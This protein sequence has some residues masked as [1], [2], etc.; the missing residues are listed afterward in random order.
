MRKYKENLENWDKKDKESK[1]KVFKKKERGLVDRLNSGPVICAEVNLNCR[2][3]TRNRY[4][5]VYPV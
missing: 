2:S 3:L 5:W 4:G 1:L